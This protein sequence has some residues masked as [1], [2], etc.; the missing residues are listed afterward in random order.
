MMI[1]SPDTTNQPLTMPVLIGGLRSD[2]GLLL[3]TS[4]I[5]FLSPILALP[6]IFY[7]IYHRKRGSFLML[8]LFMGVMGWLFA[9]MHDLYRHT[10]T[11]HYYE[12]NPFSAA[13]N[14][15]N[16]A[17][18]GA[19][20]FVF[21]AF[22]HSGIPFEMMR[23]IIV[24]ISFYLLC[25]V[26]NYMI[27]HSSRIYSKQGVF[28]R[29][30]IF[31]L[32]FDMFYVIEGIR[33]GF[34]MCIY[35]YALHQLINLGNKRNFVLLSIFAGCWHLA[36]LYFGGVTFV[37]YCM[38]MKRRT[39]ILFFFI[40]LL[41]ILLLLSQAASIIGEQR[42]N[43]YL[44]GRGDKLAQYS[45]MTAIGLTVYLLLKFAAIP[46]AVLVFRYYATDKKWVRMAMGWIFLSLSISFNAVFFYRSW[47]V[48]TTIG[49][50]A[51]LEIEE[52]APIGR[53]WL[54]TLFLSSILFCSVATTRF[55]SYIQYSDYYRLFQ[56]VPYILTQTYDQKWTNYNVKLSGEHK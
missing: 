45:G 28:V 32:F 22:S 4:I 43:W 47:W 7:G 44:S 11:Y 55:H 16:L 15:I 48:F 27:D 18:N 54:T 40:M 3:L 36:F 34:S 42:A 5:F 20:S 51:F 35:L 56:P 33:Y 41:G 46:Y 29:F 19:S 37:M 6:L 17:L 14:P 30:I 53:R 12:R 21:W 9:P 25:V 2:K 50:F 38:R 26:F 10:L 24:I 49:I 31:L 8:A 13:I 39:Y 1:Q 52:Y 23:T